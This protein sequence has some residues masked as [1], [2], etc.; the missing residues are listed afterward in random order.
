M[1]KKLTGKLAS[2]FIASSC[3]FSGIAFAHSSES[4][5]EQPQIMTKVQAGFYHFQLGDA[6]I[7][8]LSDGSIGLDKSLLTN[9]HEH[10]VDKLL[11]NAYVESS[12]VDTSVNAYII[13]LKDKVILVDTGTGGLFGANLNKLSIS[14]KNAGYTPEQVTDIVVTHFHGDHIGGLITDGKFTYPNATL[15]LN[16]KEVDYWLNQDL[17]AKAPEQGKKFFKDAIDVI[18]PYIKSDKVKQF[19]GEDAKPVKLFDGML[20]IQSHGHTAGHT[21]Y[22]IESKGKKLVFWGDIVHIPQVQFVDPTVTI[23]FDSDA[24]QAEIQRQKA[25]ADAASKGYLVAVS[26][27]PFPG[28]GHLAKDSGKG[29]QWIPIPYVNN[30][31]GK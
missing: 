5:K 25:F 27:M 16:K 22:E 31:L 21:F 19:T 3:L 12:T 28:V 11:K 20:A 6:K 8:A 29:Y 2:V 26:H 18:T 14:L 30:A 7:T 4:E 24:K 17:Y 23:K 15:H 9:V 1:N 13:S 10:K